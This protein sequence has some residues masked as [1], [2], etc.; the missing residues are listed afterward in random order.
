MYTLAG[1]AVGF[2]AGFFLARTILNARLEQVEEKFSLQFENLANR[3]FDEKADKFKKESQE[4]IG[5]LLNPLRE[6]LQEFQKK[7]DDSFGNQM[8]EQIS[9]KE[10]IKHI[11]SINAQMSQQTENLTKA[12]K[13]DVKAQGNWGAVIL[14][15]ILESSGLRKD[16]NYVLQGSGL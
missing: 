4:G 11:A 16:E 2:A 13:G 7:I 3:I 6:R 12:L 8:K 14:E 10:E 1:I 9:L 15:K 5:N